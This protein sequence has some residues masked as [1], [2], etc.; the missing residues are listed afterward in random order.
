ML[1]ALTSQHP[2]F[3]NTSDFSSVLSVLSSCLPCAMGGALLGKHCEHIVEVSTEWQKTG[4]GEQSTNTSLNAKDIK[5]LYKHS[6]SCMRSSS[7]LVYAGVEYCHSSILK[8][9]WQK[10]LRTPL[11]CSTACYSHSAF[12][13]LHVDDLSKASIVLY[14]Q[15]TASVQPEPTAPP[16]LFITGPAPCSHLAAY[17]LLPAT[18][19]AQLRNAGDPCIA[20]NKIEQGVQ[21]RGSF[22]QF[23]GT[24]YSDIGF[25]FGWSCIE[26]GVGLS[27]PCGL[28]RT[29]DILWFYVA[30]ALSRDKKWKAGRVPRLAPRELS[31]ELAVV[32]S[33]WTWA[34]NLIFWSST[35]THKSWQDSKYISYAI[36]HLWRS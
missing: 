7:A 36:F 32:S 26:P 15:R 10:S 30:S 17:V 14:P 5:S 31:S 11:T 33:V 27:D 6:G 23:L 18:G 12:Q 28:L 20:A 25:S 21:L 19:A 13:R 22:P 16:K 9:Y 24:T 34:C 2:S 29:Q 8:Y 4:K 1:T 35:L 3:C